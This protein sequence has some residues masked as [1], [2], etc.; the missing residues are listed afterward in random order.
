[1]NEVVKRSWTE[2]NGCLVFDFTINRNPGDGIPSIVT[3]RCSTNAPG[4]QT[5][6]IYEKRPT[7]FDVKFPSGCYVRGVFEIC[8][9][10]HVDAVPC[11]GIAAD[12][13]FGVTGVYSNKHFEGLMVVWPTSSIPPTPDPSPWPPAP[14]PPPEEPTEPG[15]PIPIVTGST[16]EL[17]SYVYVR[18]WPRVSSE[19]L[20]FGFIAYAE[21]SPPAGAFFN[22][23]VAA[24]AQG[25][26][27]A[28]ALA[29][30]FISGNSADQYVAAM[31][32][33]DGPVRDF[34][35]LAL[36]LRREASSSKRWLET[37]AAQLDECLARYGQNASYF[38][39]SAYYEAIDRVWQSYFALVV[40]L[41]YAPHLRDEFS[42]TL[43]LA[44]VIARAVTPVDDG[45]VVVNTLTRQQI[46]MVAEASVMLPP[47]AFPLP[48]ATVPSPPSPYRANDLISGTILPYAIGDLQ[49]VRQRL[50]GYAAGE[51]ARIENVMRGERKEVSDRQL[52]RQVE[53]R[54]N[55]GSDEHVLESDGADERTSLI[56]ET[57]RTVAEKSIGKQ[58][59]NFT[60]NYGPPTQATLAGSWTRTITG[61]TPGFD[62]VTRF[63][64]NVVA[65]TVNRITRNIGTLRASSAMNQQEHSV[66]S[67]IDNIAGPTN[68]RG[69]Y[70]WLNKIYEAWVVNYGN[71]LVMEFIVLRPAAAFIL[72][73]ATLSGERMHKPLP[74]FRQGILSFEQI[75]PDNYARLCAEYGVTT[76]QPPP[77]AQM[78]STATLR[79][80]GETLIAI[81]E[82]YCASAAFV[83]CL[84]APSSITPPTIM[85]GR[86][87]APT[88]ATAVALP[89]NGETTTIPV[90][91]GDIAP[92]LSPP[93]AP[94][95]LVNFEIQSVP[96]PRL[97]DEWRIGIYGAVM[98]AYQQQRE[99]YYAET[100]GS[101]SGPAPRSPLANRQIER[102]ELKSRCVRLFLE[103]AAV[104]SGAAS[105]PPAASLSETRLEQ[106]LDEVLEWDEMAYSFQQRPRGCRDGTTFGSDDDVFTSFLQADQARVLLPVRPNQLMA[107][108]Y[109][110][111]SGE[112][113]ESPDGL[114]AALHD[115]VALIDD[116]KHSAP[117]H[118]KERKIGPPWEIV[119]PT[120]MQIID[121][122]GSNGFRTAGPGLRGPN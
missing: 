17:F 102:G 107:F 41:G 71:R 70:R 36:R 61:G 97:M 111:S 79:S 53:Y 28:E 96:S 104:L 48:A 91:V 92:T 21:G 69:I 90:S 10:V 117:E 116:V 93:S 60:A 101:E 19:D 94:E 83:T 80:G 74:P 88:G 5:I 65:K 106:F 44:H 87:I 58:Y 109:F 47:E 114:I 64:R 57:R 3:I 54:E 99:R 20:R 27:A 120:N 76:I 37:L 110:F 118:G 77:L 25:R 55:H 105:S 85:V 75:T 115:D 8:R 42:L 22:D 63:A 18:R 81:P 7:H 11:T 122:A 59:D 9:G 31:H 13:N 119:V 51:I 2:L 40:T 32:D 100:G 72:D 86:Q 56:E 16:G 23:L 67:V 15:S 52:Q 30:E 73:Q 108:L 84:T 62:D 46:A 95:V 4:E 43:W 26:E 38:T 1:V 24:C 49:L 66:S 14:L 35:V 50:M 12:I 68:L 45:P 39:S 6:V 82:G 89:T 112:I 29:L 121:E 103:R 78:I 34:A 98:A 33:L 113:W